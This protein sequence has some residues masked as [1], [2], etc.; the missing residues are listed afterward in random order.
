MKILLVSATLN[1][2]QPTIEFHKSIPKENINSCLEFLITGVGMVNTTYQLTKWICQNKP[3][4]CIQAGIAGSFKKDIEIG[5]VVNVTDDIFSELGAESEEKF[6]SAEEIGLTKDVRFYSDSYHLNHFEYFQKLRKVSG[7][8]VNSVHGNMQSIHDISNRLNPDVESM[9][10]A[11]FLQVCS[12]EKI[13]CLQ[14]R[15]I[16]NLVEKRNKDNW[17]IP[18][19]IKN[20]NDCLINYFFR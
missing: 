20:L 7:I 14:L 9:E 13:P 5:E 15:S 8:T 1:E 12:S 19:A 6:L 3:D 16:S 10:G 18:L 2:I 4:Y 11:A 17:N